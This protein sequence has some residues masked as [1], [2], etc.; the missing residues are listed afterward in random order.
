MLI[1][2]QNVA[3]SP[4]IIRTYRDSDYDAARNL[5]SSGIVE[6]SGR[7]FRHALEL[8]HI[9][10]LLSAL[11]LLPALRIVSIGHSILAAALALA[12]LWFGCRHLY[13]EYVQFSLSDDMLNI[14]K[15]YLERDG[16]GFWVAE[17]GGELVGTVAALP[18][19]EPGGEKHMELKRLSVS[20]NH[21]GKGIAKALCRTVMD[22]ARRRGCEA[23]VL[24][25]T[26]P[27]I[28]AWKMYEKMGFRQTNVFIPPIFRFKFLDFKVLAY[29][30]DLPNHR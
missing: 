24:M 5:F 27:Q 6:N 17:S 21:R 28:G 22:F 7:A 1:S 23:V 9:W 19:S 15:Y 10:L 18:S 16:Y 2:L 3:M 12:G 26:L 14:R 4:F 29:Q 8:P 13:T 25:T 30:Y 20:K 11:F